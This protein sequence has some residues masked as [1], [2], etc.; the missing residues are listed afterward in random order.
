MEKSYKMRLYFYLL[1]VQCFLFSSASAQQLK[2][3]PDSYLTRV[4][5]AEKLGQLLYENYGKEIESSELK[6]LAAIAKKHPLD[7]CGV[8]YKFVP[9]TKKSPEGEKSYVYAIGLVP[10]TKGV[11][12]GKHF[13]LEFDKANKK[14][15]KA[16]PSTKSCFTLPPPPIEKGESVFLAVSHLLS[17]TPTEFHVFISLLEKKPV[18][19]GINGKQPYD[20]RNDQIW[21][22]NDGKIFYFG[23]G[24]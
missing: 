13:R 10:K 5:N 12:F 9:F 1:I 21:R 6:A 19:V 20:P 23:N 8:S 17:E 24:S 3:I 16:I 4:A 18:Y 7:R 22:T 11:M 14:I 15:T 2:P